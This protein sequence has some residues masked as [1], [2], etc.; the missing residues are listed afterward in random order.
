MNRIIFSLVIT[1]IAFTNVYAKQDSI[2]YTAGY[3]KDVFYSMKNGEVKSE[4][5]ANWDIAFATSKM[6][7]SILINDGL[8]VELYTYPNGDTAA[9]NS[10]DTAGLTSWT[11][12]QNSEESWEEGAFGAY[13]L[14]HPDYGWGVYNMVTHNLTGDS[15]FVIKTLDGSYKK[16]WIIGKESIAG[17]YHFRF[18]DLDGSN[19][20]VVNLDSSPYST[21][22]FVYYDLNNKQLLD[23]EPDTDTW[24][25]MFTK[26]VGAQPTGGYYSVT[27]VVSNLGVNVAKLTQVDTSEID[28]PNFSFSDSRTAIGWDWKAFSMTTFTYEV[29]DSSVYFVQNID[30]DIYKLIYTGFAGTATGNVYFNSQLLSAVGIETP[31]AMTDISIFPNPTSDIIN[32]KNTENQLINIQLFDLSGRLVLTESTQNSNHQISVR[33]LPSGVYFIKLQ[34]GNESSIQKFIVQ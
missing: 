9:W 1:V 11:P 17:I 5:R 24:D 15:I 19:D 29:E 26:Y 10:I 31:N 33:E 2:S 18:A 8:G 14:G 3:S 7:S 21:K 30:G 32:I 20:T 6:S 28:W 13:S 12:M 16:I 4:L 22:N 23:R 25:I 34:S 27:G